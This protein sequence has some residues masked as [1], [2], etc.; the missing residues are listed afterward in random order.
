LN[1]QQEVKEE[2]QLT[3]SCYTGSQTSTD[4]VVYGCKTWSVVLWEKHRLKVFEN[5]V[6]RKIHGP[7]L[8]EVTGWKNCIMSVIICTVTKF[9]VGDHL[10]EDEMGRSCGTCGRE[11]NTGFW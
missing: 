1:S 2:W 7:K 5:R 11:R 8:V 9:Y 4:A 3:V 6:W 10:K